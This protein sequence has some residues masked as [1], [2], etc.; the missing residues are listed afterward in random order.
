MVFSN[1]KN[2]FSLFL[3]QI[4]KKNYENFYYLKKKVNIKII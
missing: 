4:M 2:K 1:L 3:E